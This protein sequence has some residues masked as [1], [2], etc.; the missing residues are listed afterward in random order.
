MICQAGSEDEEQGEISSDAEDGLA[1]K[2]KNLDTADDPETLTR[3]P[4][5]ISP[6]SHDNAARSQS[7]P[8]DSREVGAIPSEV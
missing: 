8:A 2:L 4:V 6:A 3:L 5:R 7:S 1:Q